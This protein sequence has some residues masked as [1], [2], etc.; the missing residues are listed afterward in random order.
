MS[1]TIT[2][3]RIFIVDP[4]NT[5]FI[6]IQRKWFDANAFA[7]DFMDD[8]NR[9]FAKVPQHDTVFFQISSCRFKVGKRLFRFDKP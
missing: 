5:G 9:R 3:S 7:E 2:F 6:T 1:V 8:Y 4:K